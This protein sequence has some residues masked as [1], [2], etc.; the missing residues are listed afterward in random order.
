VF[1]VS[2]DTRFAGVGELPLGTPV[3]EIIETLG[4][5][6]PDGEVAFVLPGVANALL[7]GSALDTPASFEAMA[8]AGSG[9]GAGGFLV[10]STATDPV[11]VAH[12][13]SRFLAIESCG[14][15]TPC[16]QDGLAVADLLD[17]VRRGEARDDAVEQLLP[18]LH[19][20]P[21]G[22][23]CDLGRQHERVVMSIL[24]HFGDD[25]L[26]HAIDKDVA[27]PLL[28]APIVDID[29]EGVAHVDED[30]RTKQPDWSH[31]ER[32]NGQ[33]PADAHDVAVD[34]G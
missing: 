32:W 20:V 30:H 31:D 3:R 19:R 12:G 22:A 13:I 34:I 25:A 2:G 23:R 15:C 1:T 10:F 28:I 17:L 9:L 8:A 5:G 24:E 7:P 21:E 29:D 14:Q 33:S 18:L 4:G 11:A 16:K 27:E 6:V 26:D